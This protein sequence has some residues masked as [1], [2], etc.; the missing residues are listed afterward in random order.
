MSQANVALLQQRI[1]TLMAE[2]AA[3]KP[4]TA[5]MLPNA[6]G[7]GNV[8]WEGYV[9]KRYAEIE[10]LRAQITIEDGAWEFSTRGVG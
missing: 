7:A 3:W 10:K 2:I 6:Q 1:D 8:D 4:G 9:E 5:P